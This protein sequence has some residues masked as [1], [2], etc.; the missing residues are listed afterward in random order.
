MTAQL[1][2]LTQMVSGAIT[3][4]MNFIELIR[5]GVRIDEDSLQMF[6]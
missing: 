3:A 2:D 6:V 4:D 1:E 5:C